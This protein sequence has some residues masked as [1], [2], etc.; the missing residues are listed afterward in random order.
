MNIME[1][2]RSFELEASK[3]KVNCV[4]DKGEVIVKGYQDLTKSQLANGY[5]DAEEAGDETLRSA[6]FGALCLRYWYKIFEWNINSSSLGLQITDFVDWLVDGINDAL[7]YRSWRPLRHE[8]GLTGPWIENPQY[9]AY[10]EKWMAEHP[11]DVD[12][13]PDAADRS[14]NFFLGAKR[15]KEYQAANKDKH[16]ANFGGNCYSIDN[17][18]DEEGHSMLDRNEALACGGPELSVITDIINNYL[19]RGK[20]IEAL[21]IDAI[22]NGDS[23]KQNKTKDTRVV[24]SV[25]LEGNETIEEEKF[26]RYISVF[27]ARRVVKHLNEIDETFINSYFST[28][29]KVSNPEKILP[30]LRSLNNTKLYK[31]LERTLLGLKANPELIDGLK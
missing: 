20:A 6:Y 26:Y 24:R 4:N 11:D 21:I 2:Q 13:D 10:R 14:I 23:Y 8:N 28:H 31:A 3:I 22:A 1:I 25:D 9:K 12:G 18:Y 15:G 5:C 16:K 30:E 7:Y 27:D 19:S 29:Y 17:T